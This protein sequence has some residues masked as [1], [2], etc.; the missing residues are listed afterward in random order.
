M[1]A[2]TKN[3]NLNNLKHNLK[4]LMDKAP[5]SKCIAVVKA[6]AYGCE[7]N[8]SYK[9]LEKADMFATASIN[10]ALE[11]RNAGATKTILLLE[12]AF[13]ENELEIAYENDFE[14]VIATPNQLKWLKNFPKQFNQIW[15]K[16]DTGMG[17]LGFKNDEAEKAIQQ[18]KTIYNES[19]IVIMTHFSC[20]DSKDKNIT[21]EQIEIF[22]KFVNKHPNSKQSLCNSAGILNFPNAHRDFIRPGIALYGASPFETTTAEQHNLKPVMSLT[23]KVLS[24]KKLQKG[25]KLGYGQTYTMQQS[26]YVAICAVGY[27]DGYSRFIPTNTPILINDKEY[28]I[29]GRV[30]MDMTAVLV[31]ETVKQDDKVECWGDNLPIEQICNF[32]KTIPH[33]LLTTITQRVI[34]N[35]VE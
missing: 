24:V 3:I 22:D 15:F 12:G 11:L 26:G 17:R 30:A 10:E 5:N 33:Q 31:D 27:A 8:K 20:S 6:N 7:A 13:E 23:T 32:A 29:V 25:E 1:R 16:L 28:Q 4:V 21:K 19:Q 9:A 2:T 14:L 35:I 34:K 18:I